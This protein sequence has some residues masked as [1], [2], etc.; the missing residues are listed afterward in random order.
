[1]TWENGIVT[2]TLSWKNRTGPVYVWDA[3]Y[4]ML[5]A[6][7]GDIPERRYG[8]GGGGVSSRSGITQ[9]SVVLKL[10]INK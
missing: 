1:M 9:D 5:G 3:G 8:E 2:C 7:H 4:S 6:R 10:K